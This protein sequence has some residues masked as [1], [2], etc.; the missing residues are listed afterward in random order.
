MNFTYETTD[1]KG[2]YET[3]EWDNMWIDYAND[4]VTPRVLYIGDSISYGS[5]SLVAAEMGSSALV[6]VYATSKGIDNCCYQDCIK[7]FGRQQ[8]A[9]DCIIFNNGLH[10][11]H[12]D[13][14]AEYGPLYE[15]MV[16]FLQTEFP[17]VPLALILT[18]YIS[19]EDQRKRVEKRNAVVCKIA[20]KYDLPVIDL[21]AV[22]AQI[23]ELLSKDGVH[24]H[25]EGYEVLGKAI[26]E[27]LRQI[28][29]K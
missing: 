23:P 27:V 5:R 10:G 1:R 29:A 4:D 20:E 22:S 26:A 17:G 14:E 21:Y 3:F 11:W 2:C 15:Q 13:D 28:L 19:D 18:T 24:F 9:R 12:L 25:R 8:K 16:Q 7:L 6:D